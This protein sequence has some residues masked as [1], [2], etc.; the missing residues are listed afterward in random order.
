MGQLYPLPTL[1]LHLKNVHIGRQQFQDTMKIYRSKTFA[2]SGDNNQFYFSKLVFPN[3]SAIFWK[4]FHHSI[5]VILNLIARYNLLEN[6]TNCGTKGRRR[7]RNF[8]AGK[9]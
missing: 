2:S 6:S 8:L 1:P 7:A 9:L 5:V 3:K 4:S